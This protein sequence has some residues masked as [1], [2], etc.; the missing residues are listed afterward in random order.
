MIH[1]V[2]ALLMVSIAL[3]VCLGAHATPTSTY[4][5]TCNSNPPLSLTLTSFSFQLN[6]PSGGMGLGGHSSP[7]TAS[8]RFLSNKNYLDVMSAVRNHAVMHSCKLTQSVSGQGAPFAPLPGRAASGVTRTQTNGESYEWTITEL[9]FT[10]LTAMGSDGSAAGP[11]GTV[12]PIGTMEATF[13][14]QNFTFGS[15]P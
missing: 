9:T 2:R 6:A 3:F 8:I 5:F 12:G 14:F 7:F 11:G 10:N 13:T 4:T 1:R 15:R